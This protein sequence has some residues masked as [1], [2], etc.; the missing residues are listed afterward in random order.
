MVGICSFHIY[1]IFGSIEVLLIL[2]K[3][4]FYFSM[5]FIEGIQG[6]LFDCK[7][8]KDIYDFLFSTLMKK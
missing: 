2:W 3:V 5:V 1:E 8:T 6:M 7:F 4:G